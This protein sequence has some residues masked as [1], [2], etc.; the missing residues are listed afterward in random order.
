MLKCSKNVI[1]WGDGLIHDYLLDVLKRNRKRS[2]GD[3]YSSKQEDNI[4][5][6]LIQVPEVGMGHPTRD[7]GHERTEGDPPN[8]SSGNQAERE[9]YGV[10]VPQDDE[11]RP[12]GGRVI[13]PRGEPPAIT[14]EQVMI[15]SDDPV[16]INSLFVNH[17][18]IGRAHV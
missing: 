18:Q 5:D 3:E 15:N 13:S 14:H 7:I 8:P 2:P 11:V 12:G 4:T 1:A 17:D 6:K 16:A 10:D 9:I